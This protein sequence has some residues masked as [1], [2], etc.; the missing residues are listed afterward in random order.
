MTKNWAL[1]IALLIPVAV[2]AQHNVT[3]KLSP[4]LRGQ[5][6]SQGPVHV[7]V[8]FKHSRTPRQRQKASG[9]PQR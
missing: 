6:T 5:R 2:F 9:E 8:Q 4:E 7:I 1:L 3:G